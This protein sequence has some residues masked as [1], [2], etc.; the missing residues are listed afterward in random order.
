MISAVLYKSL[1]LFLALLDVAE[2]SPCSIPQSSF[3]ESSQGNVFYDFHSTNNVSC[4]KK[5]KFWFFFNGWAREFHLMFQFPFPPWTLK[6]YC[7]HCSLL[8]SRIYNEQHPDLPPFMHHSFFLSSNS[9]L[10]NFLFFF[11]WLYV[12]SSM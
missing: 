2:G 10:F 5:I 7:L 12:I 11:I 8:K 4:E 3:N 6:G 9:L 1:L